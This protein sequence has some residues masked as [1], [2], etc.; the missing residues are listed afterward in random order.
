MYANKMMSLMNRLQ[1]TQT[2]LI[3]TLLEWGT[4]VTSVKTLTAFI[5]LCCAACQYS[6]D[7]C[8]TEVQ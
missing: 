5:I 4:L 7:C 1:S 8:A 2:G 6:A 3:W